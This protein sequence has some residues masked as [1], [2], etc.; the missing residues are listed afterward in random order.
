[1]SHAPKTEPKSNWAPSAR[2]ST[3]KKRSQCL[4]HLRA[5]LYQRDL[6]EVDTPM[7]S[8]AATPDAQLDSLALDVQAPGQANPVRR[9]LHTS[10]EYPMKRLL[11]AGSGDLFYLGKVFRDRDLGRRHQIEFT[12]LEWY[13]RG[14]DLKQM[15]L[16]TAELIES[17]LQA[18]GEDEG[19]ALTQPTRPLEILTWQQAYARYAGMDDPFGAN[20]QTYQAC[21]EAHRIAPIEGVDE[22]DTEL[23][24]QL[25]FTEVIEPQLGRGRVT[26]VSHYP[27]SQASL[28]RLDPQDARLALRFEVYVEGEE[29]ANG[30]QELQDPTEHRRRFEQEQSTRQALGKSAMPVDEHLLAALESGGL[31]ACSGVALGVDRL[32][33]LALGEERLEAVMPFGF[34]QA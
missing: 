10:P 31:P 6:I 22:D 29:L 9:Y 16:E 5:F 8:A 32:L 17:V 3:L 21:L 4:Q 30:Y 25:V 15:M 13:R 1:M 28:A 11:C 12:L 2:L 27:A 26:C 34:D 18:L 19:V 24:A 14:F 7:L 20:S 33:A 23:W